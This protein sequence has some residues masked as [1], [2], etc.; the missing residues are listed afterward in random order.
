[1]EAVLP[2]E[3]ST[4]SYLSRRVP[5]TQVGILYLVCLVGPCNLWQS[6]RD[7]FCDGNFCTSWNNLGAIFLTSEQTKHKRTETADLN[8]AVER[9]RRHSYT[10]TRCGGSTSGCT[11]TTE[12]WAGW[13]FIN[14]ETK[15]AP[16][17]MITQW[18]QVNNGT[19]QAKFPISDFDA[20][21][22]RS[23][24]FKFS[25]YIMF[26]PPLIVC[27]ALTSPR[28]IIL[29]DTQILFN[30]LATSMSWEHVAPDLEHCSLFNRA[31]R[32]NASCK[33]PLPKPF[34]VLHALSAWIMLRA[35][36]KFQSCVGLRYMS[37]LNT[38]LGDGR[39]KKCTHITN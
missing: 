21:Y 5:K 20:R 14:R 19:Y 12:Q 23:A 17:H 8:L 6:K 34:N 11:S 18:E 29:S 37:F 22:F 26:L 27:L 32:T 1:M 33:L 9:D 24:C 4:N 13:F 2:C 28:D 30:T 16:F 36:G 3:T 35:F 38:L 7:T 25:S 31:Q 10:A 15:G 39:C